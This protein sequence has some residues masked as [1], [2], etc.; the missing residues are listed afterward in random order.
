MK[1]TRRRAIIAL[2]ALSAASLIGCSTGGTSSPSPITSPSADAPPSADAAP[3]SSLPQSELITRIQQA[4]QINVGYVDGPPWILVDPSSDTWFGPGEIIG[5][6]IAED[7]GVTLNRVNMGAGQQ[8]PAIQSGRLDFSIVPFFA[9]PARLE[10]VD[11]TDW[12]SGGL[13]FVALKSNTKV[14]SVD[15]INSP[16]VKIGNFVGVGQLQLTQ[17]K[18]PLA[19][20]VTRAQNPGENA[21]FTEVEAG[22]VDIAPTDNSWYYVVAERFPNFKF[23]PEDCFTNPDLSTPIAVAYPKGDAGFKEFVTQMLA[24]L[25][26]ELDEALKKYADPEYFT[27][28][29]AP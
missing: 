9:T 25:K 23:I 2:I 26:P 10:V 1:P 13:C 20:Q 21:M 27:I 6:R 11:M 22:L 17:E 19:E 15:D 5:A 18:Y 4:G 12:T 3:S 16:E 24:D 28:D 14:N 29:I 7:L 8:I